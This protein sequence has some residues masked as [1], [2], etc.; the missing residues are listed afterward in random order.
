MFFLETTVEGDQVSKA[1]QPLGTPELPGG[2]ERVTGGSVYST[3][4]KT[5]ELQL[6][7]GKSLRIS[8]ALLCRNCAALGAVV[9]PQGARLLGGRVRED[10]S[11]FRETTAPVRYL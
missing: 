2:A 10:A 1:G 9:T 8:Q 4:A 7:V 11:S 5:N 3:T 6:L